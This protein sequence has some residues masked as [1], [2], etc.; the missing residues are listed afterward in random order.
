MA[1][2]QEAQSP[3]V[4]PACQGL[5]F[6]GYAH[7]SRTDVSDVSYSPPGFYPEAPGGGPSWL[8]SCIFEHN[9]QLFFR[10][11]IDHVLH[12]FCKGRPFSRCQERGQSHRDRRWRRQRWHR[13][14][15]NPK[16][17]PFE[18]IDDAMEPKKLHPGQTIISVNAASSRVTDGGFEKPSG[19][20]SLCVIPSLV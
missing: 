2:P 3:S 18:M 7:P 11:H 20:R 12:D 14:C 19:F 5:P 17:F 16:P 6:I 8:P 15:L 1:L 4:G 10:R 9:K 13:N